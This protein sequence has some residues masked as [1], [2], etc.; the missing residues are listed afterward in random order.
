MTLEVAADVNMR[1]G[2]TTAYTI[3]LGWITGF[4]YGALHEATALT[5]RSYEAVMT[6][7][8]TRLTSEGGQLRV[9]VVQVDAAPNNGMHP[10]ANSAAL[11]RELCLI[12]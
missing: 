1:V 2:R 3:E 6:V 4:Q 10:T 9:R 5:S 8:L 12:A 11:I 7:G